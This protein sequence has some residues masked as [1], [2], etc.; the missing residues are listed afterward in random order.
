MTPSRR[1]STMRMPRSKHLQGVGWVDS[2]IGLS[3]KWFTKINRWGLEELV[4]NKMCVRPWFSWFLLERNNP[5]RIKIRAAENQSYPFLRFCGKPKDGPEG[6]TFGAWVWAGNT[7]RKLIPDFSGK[8]NLTSLEKWL[9]KCQN[10][11]KLPAS[12][13]MLML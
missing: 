9:F 1:E 5:A 10:M 11:S 12:S 4:F 13:G 8:K 6:Q 7:F 3:S 2:L